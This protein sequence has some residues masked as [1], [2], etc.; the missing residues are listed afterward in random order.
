MSQSAPE[1]NP[2]LDQRSLCVLRRLQTG[3]PAAWLRTIHF[4]LAVGIV[5][6][7]SW[8]LL[9]PNPL[10]SVNGPPFRLLR[11]VDDFL[12]HCGVYTT[13]TLCT[14]SLCRD[15]VIQEQR[16]VVFGVLLHAGTTEA[17]QALIPQRHCDP[18]D[19]LANLAGVGCGLVLLMVC[20]S[21]LMS[22]HLGHQ[23]LVPEPRR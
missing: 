14:V 22:V 3:E 16:R 4:A 12:I 9:S 7:V 8:G 21:L 13:V 18:V 15:G 20:R 19:L 10:R 23:R 2:S 1:Y 11:T 17:L 6:F 5:V